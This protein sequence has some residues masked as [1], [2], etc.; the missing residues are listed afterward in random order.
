MKSA[1]LNLEKKF[2]K[3]TIELLNESERTEEEKIVQM[4]SK[5]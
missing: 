5:I 3:L 4:L 1:L 2:E